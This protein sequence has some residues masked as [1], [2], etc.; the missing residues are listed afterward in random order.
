VAV[1]VVIFV[2]PVILLIFVPMLIEAVRAAGNERRQR[3]RGGVEPGGDVYALM[4]VAYPGL[5]LAM[6]AEGA[7]RGAPPAV[8]LLTGAAVFGLAK[9]LKWW[10]IRSLG[11]FWTFRI[12]VVPGAKLVASGPYR[13]IAHPN[14]LAVSG[15]F[16]GV[17]LMTGAIVAGPIATL[18]FAA[19]MLKRMAVENQALRNAG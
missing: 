16:I 3:A 10:A 17:A 4:Q 13:Y 5:F 12:I 2:V 14:Y 15:E 8:S 11:S 19:L 9:C 18:A 1:A 6:I 7:L